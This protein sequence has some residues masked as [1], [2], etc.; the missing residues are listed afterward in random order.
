MV[1][2]S[3]RKMDTSSPVSVFVSCGTPHNDAQERFISAVEAHLRS[4]G[5]MHYTVDRNVFRS[6][7]PAETARDVIAT[8]S[9]AVVIAFE[10]TRILA[11]V[12]K[13]GGSIEGRL[14]N[15]I[16]NESHPTV[17]NQME[18][19]MA[20]SREIP[21]LILVQAGLKRQG[22]LS[23]R[24]EWMAIETE[25]SPEVLGTEKFSQVF[26]DWLRKVRSRHPDSPKQDI[27]PGEIKVG[28]LLSQLSAKQAITLAASVLTLLIGFA[29]LAFK[30]GQYFPA[31]GRDSQPTAPATKTS[32]LAPSTK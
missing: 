14:E 9:G 1:S 2:G 21:L 16:E 17:W 27:D 11:G 19:A 6:R 8:C 20:Y 15:R 23:D 13:P 22:M 4:H 32:R 25:L 18:A 30:A 24:L 29:G 31:N 26:A 7:Q 10:R 28:R 5:C 12:D 3:P